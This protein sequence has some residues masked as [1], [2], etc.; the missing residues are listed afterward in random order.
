MA[1][2]GV[3]AGGPFASAPDQR[4][5]GRELIARRHSMTSTGRGRRLVFVEPV[6]I[7]V[8]AGMRLEEEAQLNEDLGRAGQRKG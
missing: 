6:P 8:A 1:A 2:D 4:I 7:D 5:L 3:P